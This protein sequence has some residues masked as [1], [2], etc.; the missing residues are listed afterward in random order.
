VNW[1]KAGDWCK[2]RG[3]S[4]A[5]RLATIEMTSLSSQLN[6]DYDSWGIKCQLHISLFPKRTILFDSGDNYWVSA[7][8]KGS[9][10]GQ[11]LWT[12]SQTPKEFN[13]NLLYT[14]AVLNTNSIR[15][16]DQKYNKNSL[17]LCELDNEFVDC[18]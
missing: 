5:S 9:E 7:T 11:F 1:Q 16:R 8:D 12:D 15:L 3:M 2:K 13:E 14:S 17:F 18:L 6:L 10:P 4:L